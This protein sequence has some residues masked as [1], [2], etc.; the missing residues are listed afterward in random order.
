MKNKENNIKKTGYI[1]DK[2]TR[3][4][5]NC[6]GILQ[7]N[8]AVYNSKKHQYKNLFECEKCHQTINII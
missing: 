6:G 5:I 2:Y 7:F 3:Y 1:S 4:H 8:K